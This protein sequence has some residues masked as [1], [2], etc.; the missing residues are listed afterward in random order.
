MK[1]LRELAQWATAGGLI[2]CFLTFLAWFGFSK[3]APAARMPVSP[4]AIRAAG[5]LSPPISIGQ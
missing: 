1:F 5:R 3:I 2:S 4:T